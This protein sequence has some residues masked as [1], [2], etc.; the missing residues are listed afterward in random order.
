MKK[1]IFLAGIYG[2][3]KSTIC[4]Q[5]F[6]KLKIRFY[7]ASKLISEENMECY[8]ENKLV[9]NSDRNQDILINQVRKIKESVFILDG[10][11]CIQDKNDEIIILN[12]YIYKLLNI[13]EIILIYADSKLVYK[14]LLK[15]D[16]KEYSLAFIEKLMMYEERQAEIVSKKYNIPLWKIELKY[17]SNDLDNINSIISNIVKGG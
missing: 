12:D 14:N 2:V 10:H 6:D 13:S 4:N 5:I 11:F 1:I 7:S 16:N 17:N 8:G 3:G 15:R 9:K